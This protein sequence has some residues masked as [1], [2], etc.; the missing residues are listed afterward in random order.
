MFTEI[1]YDEYFNN[2]GKIRYIG[3]FW[4]LYKPVKENS[5]Y[6]QVVLDP[7]HAQVSLKLLNI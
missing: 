7:A 5:L 2:F 1:D 6:G 3:N 4:N